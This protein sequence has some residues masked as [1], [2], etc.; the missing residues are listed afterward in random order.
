MSLLGH[1]IFPLRILGEK[2]FI[3]CG[4]PQELTLH[5][6]VPTVLPEKARGAAGG[7]AKAAR[8]YQD[9]PP[10]LPGIGHLAAPIEGET[11]GV[12]PLQLPIGERHCGRT[13]KAV[14]PVPPPAPPPPPAP[15]RPGP[16]ALLTQQR[17]LLL[18]GVPAVA[19]GGGGH[20]AVLA[21]ALPARSPHTLPQTAEPDVPLRAGAAHWLLPPR[22]DGVT[23]GGRRESVSSGCRCAVTSFPAY[24]A[25]GW[26]RGW[27]HGS[28]LRGRR[29]EEQGRARPFPPP[30]A[31]PLPFLP[32]VR[33]QRLGA[34]IAG[35]RGAV[36][37]WGGGAAGGSRGG[38]GR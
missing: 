22:R 21:V 28:G 3:P 29:A 25:Q 36:G 7:A 24:A 13:K 32:A 4:Q 9:P 14:S 19:P 8:P 5:C 1:R 34:G 30:G 27:S 37:R 10:P 16:T 31:P 33:R 20:S 35:E 38:S 26:E 11:Y 15:S 2:S 23:S 17:R 6:C 18:L 12:G